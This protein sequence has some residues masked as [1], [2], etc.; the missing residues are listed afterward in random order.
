MEREREK[1]PIALHPIAE[2]SDTKRWY[3]KKAIVILI[4]LFL[5]N[6]WIILNLIQIKA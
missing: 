2:F 4:P 6:Q 3:A 1:V 5:F